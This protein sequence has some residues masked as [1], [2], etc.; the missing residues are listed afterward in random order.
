MNTAKKS[1]KA[2]VFDVGD[3]L[4]EHYPSQSQIRLQ[5]PAPETA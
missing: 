3:T 1:Y 5:I 4:L 2:I